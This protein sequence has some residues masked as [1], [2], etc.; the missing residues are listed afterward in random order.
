[1]KLYVQV[2][3]AKDDI[4]DATV[5]LMRTAVNIDMVI[6]SPSTDSPIYSNILMNNREAIENLRTVIFSNR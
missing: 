2:S 5:S 3:S 1:M 4:S 6:G